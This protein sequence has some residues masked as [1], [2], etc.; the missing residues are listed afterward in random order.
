[1][2]LRLRTLDRIAQ[3]QRADIFAPPPGDRAYKLF[4]RN[5]KTAPPN[6]AQRAFDSETTAHTIAQAHP[7]LHLHVPTYFGPA[8]VSQVLEPNGRDISDQYW[9]NL[10]FAMARLEPDRYECKVGALSG[11]PDWHL[12]EQLEREF[13]QAGIDLGDASVLYLSTGRPMFVDIQMDVGV[14]AC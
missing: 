11:G 4:R 8:P 12:L 13:D 3:G 1:M 9:L 10:C 7:T 14:S 2:P 6:I 5:I